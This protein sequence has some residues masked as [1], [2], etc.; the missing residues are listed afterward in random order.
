MEQLPIDMVTY[1]LLYMPLPRVIKF[2]ITHKRM[3]KICQNKQ[4][5]L[6][7]A[8]KVLKVDDRDKQLEAIFDKPDYINGNISLA[9][10][11]LCT[12]LYHNIVLPGAEDY[13]H[14]L[15]CIE[16]S[17]AQDRNDY[18]QYFTSDLP[19]IY[20]KHIN[21]DAYDPECMSD[22]ELPDVREKSMSIIRNKKLW[23]TIV[24]LIT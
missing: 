19:M 14:I 22:D 5:W 1:F 7:K 10:R 16:L 20:D 21:D 8:A 18:L 2:S 23:G 13:I 17:I 9:L 15:F 3:Y 24:E 6:Q 4:F 12:L 11:Y